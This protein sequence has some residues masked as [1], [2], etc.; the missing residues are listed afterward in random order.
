MQHFK[1]W[2]RI[3]DKRWDWGS[4]WQ[5]TIH[6]VGYCAGFTD[7]AFEEKERNGI[8]YY[9]YKGIP[10]SKEAKET[11]EK[12]KDKYHTDGHAT[13]DEAAQCYKQYL[14]DNRLMLNRKMS[15]MQKKCEICG[16]WT[17]LMAQLDGYHI[18]ILCEKHQTI[19]DAASLYHVSGT[20]EFWSS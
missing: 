5:N 2:Q 13:A 6:P 1:A 20:S 16:E 7:Y 8:V 12:Y 17:S 4:G 14:L 9:E 19:E 11:Y 15:N 10:W 3:S 18:F